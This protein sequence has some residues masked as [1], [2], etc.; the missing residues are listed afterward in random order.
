[1]TEEEIEIL[2]ITAEVA[3]QPAQPARPLPRIPLFSDLAPE[4]FVELMEKCGFVRAEPGRRLLE[5]GTPGNSFFV[6]CS[7][8][9]RVVKQSDG[10][11]LTMA[12]LT[13][14]AFFGELALLAGTPRAATVIAEEESELLEVAA[15]VSTI[16]RADTRTSLRRSKQFGRQ[17]LLANVMATSALFGLSIARIASAWPSCSRCVNSWRERRW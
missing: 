17:R 1:M 8:K 14:G 13:E 5:E 6:I 3:A 15:P 9:M 2:S 12:Y 11:E 7:G 10:A 4:V 16:P